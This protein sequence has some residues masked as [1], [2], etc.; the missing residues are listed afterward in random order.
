[1][2]G[3]YEFS[4]L[5][6]ILLVLP[7]A[8]MLIVAAINS[9]TINNFILKTKGTDKLDSPVSNKEAWEA[10]FKLFYTLLCFS[11]LILF[12]LNTAHSIVN[13]QWF[14]NFFRYLFL[15]TLIGAFFYVIWRIGEY[16]KD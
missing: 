7:V 14:R 4:E 15:A 2:Y 1:M 12:F 6:V 3:G 16:L 11:V 8:V 13:G 5:S 9:D 10:G